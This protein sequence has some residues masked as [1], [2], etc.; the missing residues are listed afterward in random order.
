MLYA[1]YKLYH[2]ISVFLWLSN[3]PLS[4]KE[5]TTTPVFLP[6][7][8]HGQRSLAGYSPWDGRVEHERVTH[9]YLQYSVTH[10]CT[11]THTHTHACMHT[12]IYMH[13]C[14]R[15]HMHTQ[16]ISPFLC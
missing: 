9:T 13:T 12:R 11:H 10:T 2:M 4:E 14:T 16:H 3:I 5:V 7:E 6:R 8:L 1:T 15:T